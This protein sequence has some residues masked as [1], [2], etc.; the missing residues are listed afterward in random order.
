MF[1][2]IKSIAENFGETICHREYRSDVRV[3]VGRLQK[4]DTAGIE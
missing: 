4:R 3:Y 1:E 2:V